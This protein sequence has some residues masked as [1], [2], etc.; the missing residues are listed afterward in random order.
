MTQG[1]SP[2]AE[3]TPAVTP[4][5]P[6]P[7]ID[8]RQLRGLTDDTGMFQHALHNVPDPNHGYCIDDNAR[9]LIATVYHAQLRGYDER[10]VPL[11][12]YLQ[13]VAYAFNETTNRFRN[14]MSYDRRWLE[15][16]GSEDSHA[17]AL[18]ALGVTVR[19]APTESIRG[20]ADELM[21]LGLRVAGEQLG[22]V[23]PWSFAL[24]GLDDY[25]KARPDHETAR[26]LFERFAESSYRMV[27]QN[28][29]GD[30]PWWEDILTWGNPRLPHALLVAGQALGRD[31]MVD[32]ALTALRWCLQVQTAAEGHL[33]IVGNEGG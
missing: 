15:E 25:L 24:L 9:A 17:R 3:P 1:T 4:W 16:A 13:F 19:Y 14:F 2:T 10:V 27:R 26:D 8:L 20:L 18:W 31:E 22:H 30:W 12:R 29:T 7:E 5:R 6:M 28:A 11:H 33:S 21:N 32:T 23:R